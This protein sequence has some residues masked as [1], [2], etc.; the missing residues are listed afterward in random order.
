MGWPVTINGRTWTS[1]HFAPYAYAQNFP[2]IV[3]DIGDVGQSVQDAVALIAGS[4]PGETTL[5]SATTVNIGGTNTTRVAIT[6]TAA[7]TSLGTVANRLRILR[8]T[9]AATLTHNATRLILPG[10]TDI[11][12]AA[13]DTALA[14]SDGS[15]NWRLY[16]YQRGDGAPGAGGRTQFDQV[17]SSQ[18]V[19]KPTWARSCTMYC[20]GGGG[21]GGGGR[22]GAA[23]SVRTG[24]G[25]GGAGA[26][27]YETFLTSELGNSAVLTVT[28]AAGGTGGLAA[29]ADNTDGTAGG[30]GGHSRVAEGGTEYVRAV[31]GQGGA[32][33]NGSTAA[34]GGAA[35]GPSMEVNGA[36]GSSG[37]G[38]ALGGSGG[39]GVRA[40]G[41]G[42]SGG[43]LTT[44]NVPSTG[45]NAGPGYSFV[46]GRDSSGGA[47]GAV[48]T[49]GVNGQ[50]SRWQRG[51]G[52]GGGGGGA[53]AADGSSGGGNGGKGGDPGGGGGGGGASANG[54]AS[55]A[56]GDGGRGEV[57]ILWR[58]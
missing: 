31:G 34:S 47:L 1:A 58:S 42:G 35:A 4:A 26:I 15:G 27:T 9:G 3:Q 5:A 11:V 51:A 38:G 40:S 6:G 45:R 17:T 54:A 10:G 53:G 8:F 22:R 14:I 48:G 13:G 43:G 50:G 18:D 12:T 39:T 37:A 30:S 52:G 7:I 56:G 33:G 41:G 25:G 36:G 44:G 23:G 16:D 20:V 46:A 21:G 32:A 24:G 29:L 57:W 19:I 28:V 55:G 2:D 49:N